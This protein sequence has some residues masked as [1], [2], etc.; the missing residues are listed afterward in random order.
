MTQLNTYLQLKAEAENV[1][2]KHPDPSK[3]KKS[4]IHKV[5]CSLK[6]KGDEALG[7]TLASL[8]EQIH[9][10]KHHVPLTK[11]NFLLSSDQHIDGNNVVDDNESY[12]SEVVVCFADESTQT[13]PVAI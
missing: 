9:K 12:S 11:E 3:W 13:D 8:M 2:H 6:Q 5:V 7:K 4:H 10:W 1:F